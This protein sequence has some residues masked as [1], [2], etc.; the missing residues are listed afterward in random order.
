MHNTMKKVENIEKELEQPVDKQAFHHEQIQGVADG[1]KLADALLR[2]SAMDEMKQK[3]ENNYLEKILQ[4]SEAIRGS[5]AANNQFY[6]VNYYR[7]LEGNKITVFFKKA[8]RKV[9]YFL[10]QPVIDEQ[11]RFN[12][13][14]TQSLN[15]IFALV[16]KQTAVIS[17]QKQEINR[18]TRRCAEAE[19]RFVD[20][21]WKTEHIVLLSVCSAC[22]HPNRQ[23]DV[24][25]IAV[26]N[27]SDTM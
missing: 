25:A 26:A 21:H 18:L 10:L 6:M 15:G 1:Q 3:R 7:E 14:V 11:N 27:D 22:Y 5:V 17:E 9:L 13:S 2:R 23:I 19:D 12:A 24:F 4:E 16:E 20:C 8:I